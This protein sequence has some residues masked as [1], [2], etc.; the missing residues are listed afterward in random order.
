MSTITSSM[1][2]KYSG[3]PIII[4]IRAGMIFKKIAYFSG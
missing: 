3:I 2:T 1:C 4:C